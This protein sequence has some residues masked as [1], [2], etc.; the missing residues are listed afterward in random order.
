MTSNANKIPLRTVIGGFFTLVW[1]ILTLIYYKNVLNAYNSTS[2]P[3][4]L[5]TVD[6]LFFAGSIALVAALFSL[7]G[8]PRTFKDI[9]L[10]IDNLLKISGALAVLIIANISA[11]FTSGILHSVAVYYQ[12]WTLPAA[13]TVFYHAIPFNRIKT[14]IL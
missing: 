1:W 11:Y 7:A 13:M 4:A 14:K 2:L 12:I 10:L 8:T 6:S 3:Y 5:L 9:D